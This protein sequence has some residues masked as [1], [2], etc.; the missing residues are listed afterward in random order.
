MP[1]DE[2]NARIRVLPPAD[3]THVHRSRTGRVRR[4]K[5]QLPPT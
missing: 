4:T 2:K 1:P 3:T 5:S